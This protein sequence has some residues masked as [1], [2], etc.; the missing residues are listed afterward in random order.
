MPPC[1]GGLA[2]L[3]VNEGREGERKSTSAAM[4]P[5]AVLALVGII[6]GGGR[7]SVY[8]TRRSGGRGG[9]IVQLSNIYPLF[10]LDL[11]EVASMAEVPRGN[12]RIDQGRILEVVM[13]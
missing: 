8:G 3:C 13:S 9:I 10:L 7:G 4:A 5:L 2:A 11:P 1:C 6:L 12:R